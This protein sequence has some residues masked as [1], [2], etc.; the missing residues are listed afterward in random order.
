MP[1]PKPP[2]RPGFGSRLAETRREQVWAFDEARFGLR[3]QVRRRWCPCRVRPPWLVDDQYEWLW[4]YAA[5]EPATGRSLFLFLPGVSKEWFACFLAALS[6]EVGEQRVGLV[7]DNSSSH[8]ADM[9]W[10]AHL[11]PLPLP[12]YSPELNPAEQIF[13]VLRAKLANRIFD[14]VAELEAALTEQLQRFWDEPA[15]LHQ[16]T[17]YPWWTTG[18]DVMMLENP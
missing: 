3:I 15:I 12:S 5:V 2:S 1:R 16:L 10:P 9:A 13:R 4:L 14:T 7:L 11:T 8:R 6:R 18:L 17:A